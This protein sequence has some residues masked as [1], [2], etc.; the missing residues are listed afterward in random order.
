MAH[1]KAKLTPAG[2][3]LLVDRIVREGWAPAHA[4]AMAG[5]SRATAYKWL[6]RWRTEGEVGLVDRSSRP[7][8]M[9][10]RTS[11]EREAELVALRRSWRRGPHLL[12]GRLGMPPSTVHAVLVRHGLSRLSRMDRVTGDVIRY[13]RDHPGELVHVDVK[14]I[15]R[16][17]DGGGWRVHGRQSR[18][19]RARGT[20]FDYLH[21]AIDDHSR[22][23]F[24]QAH[25]DERGETCARF[26]TDALAFFAAHGVDVERVMTDNAKNYVLSR[27]FQ[28]A[29]GSRTHK[30][31]RA[32]RP[33]TNGKVERFNR[34]LTHEWA[35][36]RAF[37]SNDERL[38]TLDA[39]VNDYN[40]TR[41]HSAL[42]N[43]PPASRL[44]STT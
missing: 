38:A 44:P 7:H 14:K 30:R 10:C 4:A 28:Q 33:Q 19:G 21:V 43:Q 35:Y 23:A 3:F 6:G 16:V 34:T 41:T 25:T 22:V 31:I 24:V 29:L 8:S 9:P 40:W 20:G 13:E 37:A 17:P 5:V 26:L 18:A 32:Y 11:S 39:W 15:G 36:A 27:A 2:R 1:G 12:G 42:G